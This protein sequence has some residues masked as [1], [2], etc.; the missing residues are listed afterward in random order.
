MTWKTCLGPHSTTWEHAFTILDCFTS[1]VFDYSKWYYGSSST[2]P[3]LFNHFWGQTSIFSWVTPTFLAPI[4]FLI[5]FFT[6]SEKIA[7]HCR[8]KNG[9]LTPKTWLRLGFCGQK[10]FFHQFHLLSFLWVDFISNFDYSEPPGTIW[11]QFGTKAG[12]NFA[13]LWTIWSSF[14]SF[15]DK[16]GASLGWFLTSLDIMMA[17]PWL[18]YP[19]FIIF[20][21]KCPFFQWWHP[22]FLL[23]LPS[24]LDF[25]HP[26]RKYMDIVGEKMA[27]WPQKPR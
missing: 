26:L 6:S 13:P 4:S 18:F 11:D 9:Y 25:S 10:P 24:W 8:W 21:V 14:E 23:R 1:E 27:I 3:T 12:H 20:G 15:H 19:Y 22:L 2:I 16:L 7:G 17:H 5:W